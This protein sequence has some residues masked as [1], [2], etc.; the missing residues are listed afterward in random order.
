MITIDV[1]METV[2]DNLPIMERP[3]RIADA[4]FKAV[5]LWFLVRGVWLAPRRFPLLVVEGKPV[6][7][8]QRLRELIANLE[9]PKVTTTERQEHLAILARWYYSS[10]RDGEF[11]QFDPTAAVP[12]RK[13][14][15]AIRRVTRD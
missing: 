3:A 13:L 9:R 10:W 5:E 11:L 14:V 1:C 15:N 7:L 2:F 8:D 6:S 12:Y 4:G